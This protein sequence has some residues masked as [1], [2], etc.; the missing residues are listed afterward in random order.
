M[1]PWKR[2]RPGSKPW[3]EESTKSEARCLRSRRRSHW[4]E[5]FVCST[6]ESASHGIMIVESESR[7]KCAF[8][9]A[10]VR[11]MPILAVQ[12]RE[13]PSLL[14]PPHLFQA[15]VLAHPGCMH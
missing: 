13:W 4:D 3:D 1:P 11:T 5:F 12:S 2:A 15:I 6:P 8:L 7:K 9:V 10:N 14:H